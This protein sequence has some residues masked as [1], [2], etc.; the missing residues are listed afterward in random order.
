VQFLAT[1]GLLRMVGV[2]KCSFSYRWFAADG[3][4]EE[5]QFLATACL[6][7]MVGVKKC[8]F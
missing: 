1:A 3:G 6:L 4:C 5:V 8:S 2:K 7:R